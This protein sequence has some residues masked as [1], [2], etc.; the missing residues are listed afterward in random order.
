MNNKW[1][2]YQIEGQVTVN[3]ALYIDGVLTHREDIILYY[4]QTV[5]KR[6]DDSCYQRQIHPKLIARFYL[7]P[8]FTSI[9]TPA[10]H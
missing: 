5:M 6:G 10:T 7:H 1:Y 8:E 9:L 4:G 2:F 3:A